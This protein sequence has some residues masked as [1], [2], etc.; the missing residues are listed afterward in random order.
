MN[1]NLYLAGAFVVLSFLLG[2]FYTVDQR[3]YGMVF[4][5]GEVVRVADKPGL[6]FKL[7]LI[8]SISY[9]D[10]RILDFTTDE[11]EL[12]AKDLKRL[13]VSA[14]TK[15]KIVSPLKFYQTVQTEQGAKQR[16][17]S[18]FE[19]SLRQVLGEVPLADLLTDK[20]ADIMA[21]IQEI[22]NRE[23]E[24]FGVEV[25][26]VRIMRSDLPEENQLAIFQRMQSDR[27]KEAKEFRAQGA[28]QADII[29]SE[30]DKNKKIILAEAAKSA[31]IL[32]GEGDSEAAKLYANAFA[33]DTGFFSF[34]RS[35]EAY[36]KSLTKDNT[37]LYLSPDMDYLKFLKR[38]D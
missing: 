20:R 25:V 35:M 38:V 28:E 31:E 14:F 32:K 7:P 4:Q 5:F 15:Y 18:I 9:L 37:V 16:L 13:I 29:T 33:Q 26:D 27:Q 36:K 22:S 1:R 10:K 8:Q 21:S 23:T 3:E 2:S 12:I 34:V 24:R 6:H 19:S 17:N 30:A 11:K